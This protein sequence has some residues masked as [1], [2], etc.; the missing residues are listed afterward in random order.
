MVIMH[1]WRIQGM[2][3]AG[4]ASLADL[5]LTLGVQANGSCER[6]TF[7]S[8]KLSGG[9]LRG[10]LAFA[11]AVIGEA[12]SSVRLTCRAL[13]DLLDACSPEFVWACTEP[14]SAAWRGAVAPPEGHWAGGGEAEGG[15][16]AFADWPHRRLFKGPAGPP[17]RQQEHDGQGFK[18]PLQTCRNWQFLVL[19]L[20]RW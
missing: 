11:V 18:Q 12:V 4:C 5:G 17:W 6:V 20:P 19:H 2:G 3:R 1:I 10:V 14:V 13:H 9:G 7:A 16:E 15:G 8:G